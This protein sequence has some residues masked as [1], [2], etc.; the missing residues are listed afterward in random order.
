M[1]FRK[2][3]FRLKEG[4]TIENCFTGYTVTE[5]Y[6]TLHDSKSKKGRQNKQSSQWYGSFEHRHHPGMYNMLQRKELKL[7]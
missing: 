1:N 6:L 3:S 5:C 7:R 2:T 4:E